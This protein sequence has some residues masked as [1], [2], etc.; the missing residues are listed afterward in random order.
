MVHVVRGQRARPLDVGTEQ[1]VVEHVDREGRPHVAEH[2]VHVARARGI[3]AATLG[4]HAL[5]LAR[6]PVVAGGD[7]AA[8]RIAAAV[9]AEVAVVAAVARA[10]LRQ[11]IEQS[12]LG[13]LVEVVVVDVDDRA[14]EIDGAVDRDAVARAGDLVVADIDRR[15]Q[16]RRRTPRQDPRW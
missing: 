9:E 16:Y 6:A 11:R 1:G 10:A 12:T 8:G 4:Q 14:A 2:R 15:P 3:D 7:D 13:V 5:V